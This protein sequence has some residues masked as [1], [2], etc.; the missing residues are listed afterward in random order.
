M[1]RLQL[2]FI[3]QAQTHP[4]LD[5]QLP[6]EAARAELVSYQVLFDSH[7]WE[8]SHDLRVLALFSRIMAILRL[9]YRLSRYNRRLVA[10]Y[11]L[12]R[13]LKSGVYLTH[14]ACTV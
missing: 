5:K 13:T 6:P 14:S 11:A 9:L 12:S 2:C 3:F 7:K 1:R 4:S 8:S 10:C